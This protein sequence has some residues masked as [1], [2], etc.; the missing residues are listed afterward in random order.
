MLAANL[1]D[2]LTKVGPRDIVLLHDPQ[3]AAMVDGLRA[4]GVRVVWRCHVGSDS[5]NE[6]T[7]EAWAF[8]RHYLEPAEAFVMSRAEYAPEWMDGDRV[9][10]IPPSIDPFSAKNRDLDRR[11]VD[12]I[13]AMVGLVQGTAPESTISF[14]R[15][16][17][18]V[19]WI[20]PHTG[21]IADGAPPPPDARLIVQVSRW[22][23]LKDM[24]GVLTS[25]TRMAADG[26]TVFRASPGG[27]LAEATRHA[28]IAFEA[29]G[30]EPGVGSWSVLATG[31]AH[32]LAEHDARVLTWLPPWSSETDVVV[33]LAPQLLSGRRLSECGTTGGSA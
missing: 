3:T 19:G 27:V 16:D 32:H 20:R 10:V 11:T 25:F 2:I 8:L 15:R 23:R 5:R 33:A 7:E 6:E 1:A 26:P 22:D 28:V 31:V 12:G 13:L 30:L 17:G 9:V 21:L 29:D 24:A 14:K 18:S 4:T